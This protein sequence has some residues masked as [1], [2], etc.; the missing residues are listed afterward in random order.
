MY[1]GLQDII[2]P[3]V[4]RIRVLESR[5]GGMSQADLARFLSFYSYANLLTNGSFETGDP[6]DD[7]DSI[8]ADTRERSSTY[9]KFGSYS[10][11]L[12]RTDT[13]TYAYQGLAGYDKYKGKTLIFGIWVKSDSAYARVHINDG[14]GETIGGYHTGSGDWEFLT[15]SR[16]ISDSATYVRFIAGVVNPGTAYFDGAVAYAVD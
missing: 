6:P 4:K 2:E 10:L 9:A 15:V 13:N 12:T 16:T 3:L 11:K 5:E 8:L 7:W 1:R 14:D